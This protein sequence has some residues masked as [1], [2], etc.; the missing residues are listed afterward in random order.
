VVDGCIL[1]CPRQEPLVSKGAEMDGLRG[2]LG[3]VH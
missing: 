3:L 2:R 1:L